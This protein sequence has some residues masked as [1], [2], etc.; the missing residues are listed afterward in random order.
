MVTLDTEVM[1]LPE[2]EVALRNA[3][4]LYIPGGNTFLLNHRLYLARLIEPLR[5]KVNAGL[6]LIGFSAGTILCGPNIL[7][8][9]DLNMV[10]TPHFLALNL[11]PFNFLVH[12]VEGGTE[13]TMKDE[14]L[15]EYHVFHD[16]PV[17][18]MADSAYVKVD[19][20]KTSLVRGEA[21]ILHKGREK[22]KLEEGKVI[23]AI[24]NS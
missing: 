22:Q 3:A 2:M 9:S 19:G 6:P 8:S 21:W 23:S 13:G 15:A 14:W 12:Y 16:N 24:L 10:P 4:L 17:I 11:L 1:P 7:T 18:I 20:K 5:R